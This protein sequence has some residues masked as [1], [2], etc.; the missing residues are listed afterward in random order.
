MAAALAVA[1]VAAAISGGG[2]ASTGDGAVGRAAE[3]GWRDGWG[4]RGDPTAAAHR[5]ALASSVAVGRAAVAATH[6]PAAAVAVGGA[7]ETRRLETGW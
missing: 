2:G 3:A 6:R 1:R 5:P 4:R 7:A